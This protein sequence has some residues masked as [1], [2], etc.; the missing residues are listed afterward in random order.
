MKTPAFKRLRE[1]LAADEPIYGHRGQWEGPGV[2]TEL[3][4]IKDTLRAE[5]KHC[6]ILSTSHENLMERR[7]Q[8][9]RMLGLGSD[10]G[11]LLPNLHG[12]L[13]VAGQDRHI[14]PTFVSSKPATASHEPDIL[15][16]SLGH[17]QAHCRAFC[18]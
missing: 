1:K 7:V 11:L 3:L 14:V 8:G 5:G 18:W 15:I 6:G 10:N 9:F 4:A 17:R 2:A 16:P 12:A 13:G